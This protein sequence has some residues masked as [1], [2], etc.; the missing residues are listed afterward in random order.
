MLK[1]KHSGLPRF[2]VEAGGLGV[3]SWPISQRFSCAIEVHA[4]CVVSREQSDSE[5]Y[6]PKC[7]FWNQTTLSYFQALPFASFVTWC[8]SQL[9]SY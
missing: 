3:Q 2:R 9:S 1:L 8:K 4:P 7:R 5:C 6:V